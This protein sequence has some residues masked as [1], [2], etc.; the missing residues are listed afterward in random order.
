MFF[1][2]EESTISENGRVYQPLFTVSG[3]GININ[4]LR[5]KGISHA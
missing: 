2:R 5:N 4:F 3:K 1:Y